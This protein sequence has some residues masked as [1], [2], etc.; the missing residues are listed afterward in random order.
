MNYYVLFNCIY[1]G[2]Y[3]PNDEDFYSIIMSSNSSKIIDEYMEVL[4]IKENADYYVIFNSIYGCINCTN[5][6]NGAYKF[7]PAIYIHRKTE[8]FYDH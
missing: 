4:A 7:K 5:I 6:E 1:C 3:E 2:E 8:R